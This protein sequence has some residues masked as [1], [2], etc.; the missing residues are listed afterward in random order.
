MSHPLKSVVN[1]G[2]EEATN[3]SAQAFAVVAGGESR[4]GHEFVIIPL[5]I[6]QSR[7]DL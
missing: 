4:M 7:R 2:R 1:G 3:V 5:W 6:E